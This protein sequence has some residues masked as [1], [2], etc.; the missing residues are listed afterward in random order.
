MIASVFLT[1][2]L[3]GALAA[4]YLIFVVDASVIPTLPEVFIVGFYYLH[5][6]F[7]VPPLP[8]AVALLVM[9][10][11]GEATGNTLLYLVVN[12][13]LVRT[14]RMPRRIEALM[15][16]WTGFLLLHDE[17]I[18]LL[19]R[20]IPVLPFVGAFI[21]GLKWRYPRSLAFILIG[22]GAKYSVLL[23]L[24]GGIGVAYD[25][26]LAGWITLGLVVGLVAA[27]AAGSLLFR[28]HAAA[29]AKGG[30]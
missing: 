29:R 18:I 27:S 28:R 16:R 11:A 7:G 22:A 24:V 17:R 6:L 4:M 21:A 25:P 14:G 30:P 26:A 10:L 3:A 1:I 15:R 12:H 19:N 23:L 13:A 5:A 2:G 8:W 20:V 9:A